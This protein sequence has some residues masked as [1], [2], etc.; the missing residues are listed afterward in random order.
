MFRTIDVHG[1]VVDAN[2]LPLVGASVGIKGKG[3]KAGSTN[4]KGEFYLQNVDENA[5]LLISFIGYVPKEVKASKDVG[6]VELELSLSK[7]DERDLGLPSN[8]LYCTYLAN[9]EWF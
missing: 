7:L 9:L 4:N 8:L 2:G 1:R 5:V 3:N 6:N